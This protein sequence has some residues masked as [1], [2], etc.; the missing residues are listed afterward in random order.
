[1]PRNKSGWGVLTGFLVYDPHGNWRPYVGHGSRYLCFYA[2]TEMSGT[3]VVSKIICSCVD[4]V[5]DIYIYRLTKHRLKSLLRQTNGILTRSF[6]IPFIGTH[7]SIWLKRG[8]ANI[9]GT[10]RELDVAGTAA[11]KC[12]TGYGVRV[13]LPISGLDNL[14]DT[15]GGT[16]SG[17]CNRINR[18]IHGRLNSIGRC[19]L[20]RLVNLDKGSLGRLGS[21][22]RCSIVELILSELGSLSG[23]L[24]SGFVYHSDIIGGTL[25]F[26]K[27][28][29]GSRL[30]LMEQQI[31]SG[32]TVNPSLR[33]TRRKTGST[34]RK[35][36]QNKVKVRDYIRFQRAVLQNQAS[37]FLQDQTLVRARRRQC[38]RV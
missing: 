38:G 16:F 22:N 21:L 35:P 5:C 12:R 24:L 8:K 2:M 9:G 33:G 32:D 18:C 6:I 23:F 10:L 1:M 20:G 34:S 31:E 3:Y 29:C 19:I 4:K 13:G 7:E 25:K 26:G 30:T 27:L 11:N 28:C 15:I 17:R 14:S 37:G 36:L